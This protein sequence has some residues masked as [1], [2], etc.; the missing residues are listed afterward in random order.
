MTPAQ[1]IA[2][3]YR[4]FPQPRPFLVDVAAHLETGFVFST[5]DHFIMGRPVDR[6][7]GHDKI[8]DPYHQFGKD[9]ANTWFVY[10]FAGS[11][12]NFLTYIP[13]P[14]RWVTWSR[15]NKPLR[16]Y[17]LDKINETI[18]RHFKPIS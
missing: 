9:E 1:Q 6:F 10:A 18:R 3:Q 14:L 11:S 7:A 4:R 8:A 2:E 15:R 12:V 13:F 5:P 17:A 16:F